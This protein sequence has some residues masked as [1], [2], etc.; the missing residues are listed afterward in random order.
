MTVQLIRKAGRLNNDDVWIH[1]QAVGIDVRN[2][3]LRGVPLQ[4]NDHGQGGAVPMTRK[5]PSG[6]YRVYAVRFYRF[7]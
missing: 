4:E 2:K 5:R 3:T 6:V 1:A 7:K